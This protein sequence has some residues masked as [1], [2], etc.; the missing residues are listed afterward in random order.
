MARASSPVPTSAGTIA[1]CAG[2]WSARAMP[3]PTLAMKTTLRSTTPAARPHASRAVAVVRLQ[4][5]HHVVL[6]DARERCT[7]DVADVFRVLPHGRRRVAPQDAIARDVR[8]GIRLPT[9]RRIRLE[10]EVLELDPRG[11][12]RRQR[13]R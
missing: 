6:R 10:P 4:A 3:S 12:R 1:C 2:A 9:Q 11:R 8:L 13:E 7:R 5:E